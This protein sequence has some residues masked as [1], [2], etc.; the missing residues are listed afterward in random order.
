MATLN[1]EIVYALPEKQTLLSFQV[2][3]GTTLEEAIEL[4]GIQ[5]HYPELDLSSMKVG[6]FGKITPRTHVMREKDRIE[7]YRP[8]LADPKE[9]RK[10]RAAAGKKM[11]KGG[12]SA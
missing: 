12:D 9:V 8:L 10:Q 5:A 7:L 2:E 3:E 1:V 11:K 6:I 4:S